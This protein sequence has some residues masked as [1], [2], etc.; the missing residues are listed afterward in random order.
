MNKRL[1]THWVSV[2]DS[3]GP[4]QTGGRFTLQL[5]I[6]FF[7]FLKLDQ[8]FTFHITLRN[9][10]LHNLKRKE[11]KS[12]KCC[13]KNPLTNQCNSHVRYMLILKM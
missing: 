4:M 2:T 1:M 12:Q 10:Q 6:L 11:K 9:W 5:S 3:F 7:P 8:M 13:I